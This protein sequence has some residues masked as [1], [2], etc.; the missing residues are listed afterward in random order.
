[1][2][3][4]FKEL[5]SNEQAPEGLKNKVMS[6]INFSRLIMDISDLFIGKMG[7]TLEGLFKTE[8]KNLKK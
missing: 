4:T 7:E 3:N 2:K 6:S 5:E 8:K 1:M